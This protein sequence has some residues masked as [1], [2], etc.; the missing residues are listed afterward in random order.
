MGSANCRNVGES[1]EAGFMLH[2]T[3]FPPPTASARKAAENEGYQRPR[4]RR[5][6][7]Q[8]RLPPAA[9]AATSSGQNCP[10]NPCVR[11]LQLDSPH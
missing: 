6:Q 10:P 2:P 8:P 9:A 7:Q 11:A 5:R 1:Q 4:R 3:I